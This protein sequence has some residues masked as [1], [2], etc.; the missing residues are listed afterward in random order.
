MTGFRFTTEFLQHESNPAAH[1]VEEYWSLE[2]VPCS[3]LIISHVRMVKANWQR[4]W[5]Q[6]TEQPSCPFFQCVYFFSSWSGPFLELL[7]SPHPPGISSPSR[8]HGF[9]WI[10]HTSCWL[11]YNKETIL[12]SRS[13]QWPEK[14]PKRILP[15]AAPSSAMVKKTASIPTQLSPSSFVKI[16]TLHAANQTTLFPFIA[17]NLTFVTRCDKLAPTIRNPTRVLLHIIRL[18]C[19]SIFM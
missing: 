17:A 19:W 9:S 13:E 14:N 7:Q 5:V 16:V 15:L 3:H 10:C 1:L 12:Y 8:N 11:T 2:Q 18:Y 4:E 6:I